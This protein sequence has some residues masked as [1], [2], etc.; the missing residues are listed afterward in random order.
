LATPAGSGAIGVIRLSG[1]DAF[2]ITKDFFRPKSKKPL[3]EIPV[4]RLFLEILV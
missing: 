1:P 3:D 4:I 2:E